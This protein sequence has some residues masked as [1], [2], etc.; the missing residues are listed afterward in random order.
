MRKKRLKLCAKA[1]CSKTTKGRFC[2]EHK[3]QYWADK[4]KGRA[5][6]TERGYDYTWQK[7]RKSYL[8]RN[9]LCVFCKEQGFLVSASEV[10]HIKSLADYPELKYDEINL[11]PLCK[12][13]HSKRTWHEQGIGKNGKKG[14]TDSV[15]TGGWYV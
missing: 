9:P 10:D 14:E 2:D 8:E 12:P 11:R 7:F 13:C 3:R 5:T 6:R 4:E 1:G 15:E